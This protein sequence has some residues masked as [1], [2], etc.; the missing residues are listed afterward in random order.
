MQLKGSFLLHRGQATTL[1]MATVPLQRQ[2]R[3][4]TVNRHEG[5]ANLHGNLRSYLNPSLSNIKLR[6]H[7]KTNGLVS[8]KITST[9]MLNRNHEFPAL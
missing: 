9:Y 1:R 2:Y 8:L 6:R 7:V 3:L 4:H 5:T